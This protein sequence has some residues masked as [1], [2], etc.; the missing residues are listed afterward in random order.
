MA[1]EKDLIEQKFDEQQ[2]AQV[3]A[4]RHAWR[5]LLVPAVGSAA[6]FASAIVGFIRTYRK[7]GFPQHAFKPFDYGLMSIPFVIVGM[8]FLYQ[9]E[10]QKQED[11]EAE[12]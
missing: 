11:G 9:A 3:L 10:E 7:Y 2:E 12:V 8:A 5:S 1:D 6:F 4:A